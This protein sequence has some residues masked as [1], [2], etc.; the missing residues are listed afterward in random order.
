MVTGWFGDIL[1][2]SRL[3]A[4]MLAGSVVAQVFNSLGAMTGNIVT[5]VIIFLIGHVLNIFLN[6]IGTFVHTCR[7]EY[8]EFFGKW[9]REGGRKFEPLAVNTKYYNIAK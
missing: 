8:L 1:S 4:L 6:L 3:M 2:Y 7:L 9:Y 5:F